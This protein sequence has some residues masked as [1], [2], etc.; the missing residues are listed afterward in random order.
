MSE[1][2]VKEFGEMTSD[3]RHMKETLDVHTKYFAKIDEKLSSNL[4]PEDLQKA[5]EPLIQNQANHNTQILDH[6]DRIRIL[7]NDSKLRKA[8]IWA[9]IGKQTETN[10]IKFAGYTLFTIAIFVAYI[11]YQQNTAKP[12]QII[13]K[14]VQKR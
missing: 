11:A 4:T 6:E 7:E 12:I 2:S 10:F 14:Q 9:K 8:S 5:I 1:I 3:V 13:E